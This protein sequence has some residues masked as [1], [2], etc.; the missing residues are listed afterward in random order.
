MNMLF[1]IGQRRRSN[2]KITIL[3]NFFLKFQES[4]SNDENVLGIR[5][6]RPFSKIYDKC[7][8]A[9]TDVVTLEDAYQYK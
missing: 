1:E 9:L 8:L 4:F 2:K 3:A 5:G 7:N 6:T